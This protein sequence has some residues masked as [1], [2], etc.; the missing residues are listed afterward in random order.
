MSN[1]I[2]AQQT[3]EKALI[4]VNWER[5]MVVLEVPP[6]GAAGLCWLSPGRAQP[7]FGATGAPWPGTPASAALRNAV[8]TD[9]VFFLF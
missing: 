7:S 1:I 5:V 2:S 3:S 4:S 8:L 6:D 9:L